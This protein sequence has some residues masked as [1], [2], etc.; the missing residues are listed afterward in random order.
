VKRWLADSRERLRNDV[1]DRLAARLGVDT[2]V[3]G[4]ILQDL[5]SQLDLSIRSALRDPTPPG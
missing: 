2:S 1:R 4:S 3:L 5:Q